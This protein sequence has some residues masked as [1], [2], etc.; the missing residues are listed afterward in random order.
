MPTIQR[1]TPHYGQPQDA[2]RISDKWASRIPDALLQ[3]Q[4]ASVNGNPV[5]TI[6]TVTKKP[7]AGGIMSVHASAAVNMQRTPFKNPYASGNGKGFWLLMQF[8]AETLQ[9]KII[10][11]FGSDSGS[12]GNTVFAGGVF[13]SGTFRSLHGGSTA[14]S[15]TW[16]DSG[17][18]VTD[19][20]PHTALVYTA[21]SAAGGTAYY[22]GFLDGKKYVDTTEAIALGD[23]WYAYLCAGGPRRTTDL[24]GFDGN[25]GLVAC[26]LDDMPDALAESITRNPWQIFADRKRQIY[27]SAASGVSAALTG[28]GVT[29]AQG[30]MVAAITAP[31]TG[32]SIPLGQGTVT[33]DPGGVSAALTGQSASVALGNVSPVVTVAIAGQS[34]PLSLGTMVPAFERAITGQGVTASLGSVVA[35]VA[36]ALSGQSITVST[37]A[38][39]VGGDIVRALTGQSLSI[40]QGNVLIP[41]AVIQEEITYAPPRKTRAPNFAPRKE[42]AKTEAKKKPK[43][44]AAPK[45]EPRNRL[46]MANE[47]I[48]PDTMLDLMQK[49]R[50]QQAIERQHLYNI[51]ARAALLAA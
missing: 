17:V 27:I 31:L 45:Q 48:V 40:S 1:L 12:A 7:T 33:V 20:K 39:S 2:A 44:K 22:K 11:A 42:P 37:G 41:G 47:L 46:R 34:I 5:T 30:S 16:Q 49:R 18:V 14:T 6:G 51:R 25:V 19:G 23:L 43:A 32:H 13:T 3:S 4:T 9:D 24:A 15:S 35:A 26:I 50:E 38:V 36:P 21:T 8:T 10:A 28:Q 29:V